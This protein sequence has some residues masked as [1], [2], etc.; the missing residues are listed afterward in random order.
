MS[1]SDPDPDATVPAHPK[2]A[3]KSAQL[4]VGSRQ[5]AGGSDRAEMREAMDP[6]NQSLG[7]AL[8]LSYRLLQIAIAGLVITFLLSGFQSI[9][10]G[11]TGIRTIFGRIAGDSASEII[12][13]GLHPFWP[14]PIGEFTTLQQRQNLDIRDAFWPAPLQK[15]VTIEMAT[16]SADTSNPIQPMRDG[17]VITADGDLAHL[18]LA[19]DYT[20]ADPVAMLSQISPD[21]S[22]ALV[23]SLLERA[24]VQTV[25][26]YSLADLLEQRDAPAQ[27]IRQHMQA[28]LD[29]LRCGISVTG[30]VLLERTAPFAVRGA[31]RRVQTAR[32]EM[33]TALERARQEANA[34]LVGAAGPKYGEVLALIQQ[35]EQL[36][37]SG[38]HAGSDEML[39]QIGRRLEQPDIG[40]E[41]SFII[42]RAKSYQSSLKAALA[43]EAR[44]LTSLA[45][46]YH[47]NPR[48][49]VQQLWL[50]AVRQAM[51]QGEVEVFAVPNELARYAIHVKSSP[52]VMQARRDAEIA[53][54]KLEAQMIGAGLPSFQLGG[55]HI[56]IGR[57][58][59]RLEK[60]GDKGFGQP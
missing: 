40:G 34:K 50:E 22:D 33:K 32:E 19:V 46:S 3:G 38:D 47:E 26:R 36:L 15:D 35:Y 4:D 16:D 18:Q 12:T 24:V 11:V 31:L 9:P 52:S 23:R 37:T 59:R 45:A 30:V 53:R 29:R 17:S 8:R 25:A 49:L 21:K 1:M 20:I 2:R 5:S 7:E 28:S 42:S 44:R 58:G 54:K 48:Q 27:E 51:T 13:P 57:P 41:A 6:A 39:A 55:R 56:L 14:Y 43:K 10:E 60:S